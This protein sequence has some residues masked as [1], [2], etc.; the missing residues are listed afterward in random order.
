MSSPPRVLVD[1]DDGL[2]QQDLQ[3]GVAHPRQVQ[4]QQQVALHD[5]EQRVVRAGLSGLELPSFRDES[6]QS[7]MAWPF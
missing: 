2:G 3:R 7:G 6:P 1:V 4:A 5:A